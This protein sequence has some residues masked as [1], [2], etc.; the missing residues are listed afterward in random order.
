MTKKIK[1]SIGIIIAVIILAGIAVGGYFIIR[2]M[3]QPDIDN[4]FVGNGA[5]HTVDFDSRGG[6]S[7]ESQ[8]VRDGNP[9]LRP[10][11]PVRE[12]Y[13]LIGWFEDADLSDEWNFDT[14]RVRENMTLYAGWQEEREDLPPTA[15]LVYQ[16]NENG[17]GYTVTDVG[18]ETVIVVPAEYNGL[19]VTAIQGQFGT[20]AFA[21]KA[22]TSVILPD[23]I[24][25]IGS[26]TFNNCSS[27]TAVA[28]GENSNL[29]AIGNNA[30][31]G[32]HAL[33]SIYIPSKM[34]QLG[35]NVFNNCSSIDFTVAEDNI[36]YR[37]ENG[38]FIEIQTQTL[39]RAGQSGVIPQG[40]KVI[41]QAAFRRINNITQ[42][43]IPASVTEIGNYIIQ[44]SSIEVVRY[45][46]T[47]TQ[48]NAIEKTNY[49]NNGKPDILLKYEQKI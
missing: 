36:A 16:L 31:S 34:T 43:Y 6:S 26:N 40:V 17:D 39:L 27:L 19:P 41:A 30:F 3:R 46:G 5:N 32:C 25:T 21:R 8:T 35:D 13:F 14:D 15:S 10:D 1:I 48:W 29:T 24:V 49:W 47:E 11:T 18:E 20:G 2:N 44:N 23:S 9:V 28:I 7:V 33:Q 45:E 4:P 12:G 37:S 42:L 38:H 22:I